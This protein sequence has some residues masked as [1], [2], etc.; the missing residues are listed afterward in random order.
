MIYPREK[1]PY[2]KQTIRI[3]RHAIRD[4]IGRI[5]W[6]MTPGKGCHAYCGA[7]GFFDV[8]K[9]DTKKE[10]RKH[11]TQRHRPQY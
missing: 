4:H 9:Q 10:G 11:G 3:L 7:C 6:W 1:H 2:I 8:C 5:L